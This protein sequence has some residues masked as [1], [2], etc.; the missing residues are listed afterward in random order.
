MGVQD[1][2]FFVHLHRFFLISMVVFFLIGCN[3]KKGEP[4]KVHFINN[5]KEDQIKEDLS[6]DDKLRIA[7]SVVLSPRESF[8][9]YKELFEYIA[10]KLNR[11]LVIKQG[12]TYQEVNEMLE[13]NEVDIA[14]IC[15]GAYVAGENAFDLLVVPLRHQRNYY[16]GLIIANKG[17]G[18]TRFEDFKGKTF[19]FT[20]PMSNTG[21]L[22]AIHKLCEL[23]VSER[24]FFRTTVYTKSH[25]VSIQMVA[26]NMIDGASVSGLVYEYIEAYQP[27]M[28]KNITIVERS[29]DFGI[30]PI[31]SSLLIPQNLRDELQK[32]FLNMH[33]D[34]LGKQVL[35]KLMVERFTLVN[36]SIYDGVRALYEVNCTEP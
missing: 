28:T 35:G 33:K 6:N 30:P 20:D 3:Y 8:E 18:V 31:V 34:E 14:F 24:E 4:V 11:V 5:E 15:S 19:A 36:D 29:I 9:Y 21:K 2:A 27:E 13:R 26:R 10:D 25:D 16:H 32:L 23:G 17:A 22:F 7:F 12:N 1:K